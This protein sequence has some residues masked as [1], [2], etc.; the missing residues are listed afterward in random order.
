M[1]LFECGVESGDVLR[2]GQL[3]VSV[4]HGGDGPSF[5]ELVNEKGEKY[6]DPVYPWFSVREIKDLTEEDIE[7]I[8]ESVKKHLKARLFAELRQHREA[9]A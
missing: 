5:K 7:G 6:F 1:Y 9:Q 3:T 4:E 2:I 8:G